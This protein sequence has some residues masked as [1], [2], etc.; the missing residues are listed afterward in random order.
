MPKTS[1]SPQALAEA[2]AQESITPAEFR[3]YLQTMSVEQQR[4]VEELM[5]E[6]LGSW[7]MDAG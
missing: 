3:K 1:M 6:E 4:E 5:G 7:T 2:A